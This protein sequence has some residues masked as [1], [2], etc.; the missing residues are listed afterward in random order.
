MALSAPEVDA[1]TVEV[2]SYDE[3]PD[4]AYVGP[5]FAEDEFYEDEY[6]EDGSL[7]NPQLIT[8]VGSDHTHLGGSN[9]KW[10]A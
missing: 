10:A 1:V 4:E 7:S 3:D 9:P 2:P 8:Q 6:E 5:T